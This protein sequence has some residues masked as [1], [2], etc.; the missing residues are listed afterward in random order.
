MAV[1]IHD[2]RIISNLRFPMTFLVVMQHSM[3]NVWTDMNWQHLSSLD[4]YCLIK[5]LFSGCVALVAVP[6]FFYIS[7]YLF[8]ANINRMDMR[9]Y[10]E[11]MRKRFSSLLVPYLSWNLLCIPILLLVTYGE[12]LNGSRPMAD[13]TGLLHSGRWGHIFWDFYSHDAAFT[14]YWGWTILKDNPVLTTFWYV[15]DLIIMSLL[16]PVIYWYIKK[17]K[18]VGF[19]CLVAVFCLRV[20]PHITLGPQ[21]LFFVFGAYGS[22]LHGRLTIDNKTGRRAVCLLTVVLTVVMLRFYGNDT[23]WGFLLAPTFTLVGCYAVL[24]LAGSLLERHPGAKPIPSLLTK[25]SFFVYALHIEFALPL[26]FFITKAVFRQTENALL[27]TLQYFITPC[28][29]YGICLLVY[30]SLQKM[31]PRVL[32][33][34]NGNR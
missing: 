14:N 13:F 26:G 29:I 9:V 12:A 21:S 18:W 32:S 6:V 25:S 2:S 17:T 23:Y 15:R 1:T 5:Y 33:W 11:K 24:N 31:M 30:V 22:M 28:L 34:L 7:G 8:F 27:L 10:K 16:T 4:L 3:G 20:W 19:W